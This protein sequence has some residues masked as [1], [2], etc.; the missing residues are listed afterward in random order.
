MNGSFSYYHLIYSTFFAVFFKETF[1]S[2]ANF[3]TVVKIKG[4]KDCPVLKNQFQM[5]KIV[6]NILFM[7]DF[8]I[9]NN[10]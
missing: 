2:R 6:N 5:I 1:K 10:H 3:D 4:D 8:S 7:V 9:S